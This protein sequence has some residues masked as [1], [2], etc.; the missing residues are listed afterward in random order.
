MKNTIFTDARRLLS[1]ILNIYIASICFVT[2]K[3]SSCTGVVVL[4]M[5]KPTNYIS[6]TKYLKANDM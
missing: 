3:Q 6:E 2:I 4:S 5:N 1:P